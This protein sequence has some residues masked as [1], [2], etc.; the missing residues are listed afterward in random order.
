MTYEN[1]QLEDDEK[2]LIQ[3]R[4]H[5]FILAMQLLSIIIVAILPVIFF[6]VVISTVPSTT[7]DVSEYTGLLISLYTAWLLIMWMTLFSIWTNYYLDIW[8]ITNKRL[9]AIDQK[10]FFFRTSASFRLERL[11]DAIVS[12]NGIIAT[13]LNYGSLEVQ[14]AGEEKNFKAYGLPNPGNL[15]SILLQ[16]EDSILAQEKLNPNMKT[17]V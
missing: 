17:V 6:I 7:L 5:W 8:T 11:Q 16:A 15:K 9:I 12:V 13:L 10:G 2:I 14:T 4:K 3:V 1:L